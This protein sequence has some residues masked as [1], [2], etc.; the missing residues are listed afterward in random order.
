MFGS[1]FKRVNMGPEHFQ[2]GSS[3]NHWHLSGKGGCIK[4]QKEEH[5]LVNI[6][7]AFLLSLQK[8]QLCVSIECHKPGSIIARQV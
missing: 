3:D 2:R 6:L 1:G 4:F 5:K 8:S 7:I